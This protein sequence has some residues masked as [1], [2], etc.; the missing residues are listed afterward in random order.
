MDLRKHILFDGGCKFCTGWAM[1]A[2]QLLSSRGWTILPL[3]TPQAIERLALKENVVPNEIAIVTADD[4][5]LWGIDGL[6]HLARNVWWLMPAYVIGSVPGIRQLLRRLYRSVAARR[7]CI[8]GKCELPNGNKN[9]V[10][11]ATAADG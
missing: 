5:V 10:S 4:R 3:Q 6:L 11:S 1:R 9:G 7:Y 8:S 2:K